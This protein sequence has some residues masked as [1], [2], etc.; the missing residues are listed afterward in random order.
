MEAKGHVFP[1][2]VKVLTSNAVRMP[3][4]EDVSPGKR[5]LVYAGKCDV[6]RRILRRKRI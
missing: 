1:G 4:T 6:K 5:K 2:W 3:L